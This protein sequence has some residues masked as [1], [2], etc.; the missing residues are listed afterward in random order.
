MLLR[1]QV[2]GK[3]RGVGETLNGR[4]E[5]AGVSKVVKT[6]SHPVSP[7]PFKVELVRRKKHFLRGWDPI[8]MAADHIFRG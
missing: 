6:S 4:V 7:L 8:T 5:E 3:R 2:V 1:E